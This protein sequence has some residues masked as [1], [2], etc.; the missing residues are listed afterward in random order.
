MRKNFPGFLKSATFNA[1]H[2]GRLW[3]SCL[4]LG[5]LRCPEIW[6]IF[7]NFLELTIFLKTLYNSNSHISSQSYQS[8]HTHTQK[9]WESHVSIT[10]LTKNP[11]DVVSSVFRE[12]FWCWSSNFSIFSWMKVSTKH[13]C[14]IWFLQNVPWS[15]DGGQWACMFHKELLPLYISLLFTLSCTF[16]FFL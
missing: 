8:S 9:K 13:P 5:S 15:I 12:A 3:R 11:P 2:M 10:E 16:L 6:N 14:F 4:S 1:S 7:S